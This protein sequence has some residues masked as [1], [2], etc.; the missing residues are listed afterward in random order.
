MYRKFARY[1]IWWKQ[2]A[3]GST[4]METLSVT[5]APKI[6]YFIYF[7]DVFERHAMF[8]DAIIFRDGGQNFT[9]TVLFLIWVL[10]PCSV[11]WN[12]KSILTGVRH[13]KSW[14]ATLTASVYRLLIPLRLQF[15]GNGSFYMLLL[16]Q[17]KRPI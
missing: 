7:L 17:T 6:S 14:S 10:S 4:R 16:W 13:M 3:V 5:N 15:S 8:L 1:F 2:N 12:R 9:V 11:V